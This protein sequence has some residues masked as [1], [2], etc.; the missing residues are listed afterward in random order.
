MFGGAAGNCRI[1]HR[2]G[3]SEN[4]TP[5]IIGEFSRFQRGTIKKNAKP[6]KKRKSVRVSNGEKIEYQNDGNAD[7][8]TTKPWKI[9]S[10]W[11]HRGEE[12][13][14]DEARLG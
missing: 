2:V 10:K 11:L 5:Q 8:P 12:G 6:R 3:E 9:E 13:I 14:A 4:W 7:E 1:R